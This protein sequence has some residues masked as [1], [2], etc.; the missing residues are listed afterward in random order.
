MRTLVSLALLVG[1]AAGCATTEATIAPVGAKVDPESGVATVASPPGALNYARRSLD[2]GEYSV[3]IPRLLQL[4]EE[5]PNTR[6]GQ[7]A[8]YYLGL[9][10]YRIGEYFQAKEEFDRFLEV[11][12]DNAMRENAQ[13]LLSSLDETVD[14]RY[15]TP[16][17]L[18]GELGE[19]QA[20]ALAN[21]NNLAKQL[22]YADLLWR[23]HRYEDAGTVYADILAGWP[24]LENDAMLRTRVERNPDG[25][26]TVLSPDEV[27]RRLA[28][29]QPLVVFN[30]TSFR[31]GR[32]RV[33]TRSVQE[34][35]FNVTGQVVNRGPQTLHNVQ[36]IVT[37]YGFSNQI[38]D[39]RTI[40]LGSMPSG[41][42]R[43]FSVQFLNF[44][45]IENVQRYDVVATYG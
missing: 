1:A 7:E 16:E 15:E 24:Q 45:N 38:L 9:A 31:S 40:G 30:T 19:V 29:E 3:A 17:E 28:E 8:H 6:A 39:T 33:F 5:Y 10:Y 44:D 18:E 42:V 41:V 14:Q 2:A 20:E 43:P 36:L 32:D 27:K 21:P 25:T 22:E 13:R 34:R 37:I 4:I 26:L 23:N 11:A 12:G 35:I